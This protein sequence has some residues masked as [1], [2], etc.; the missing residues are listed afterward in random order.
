MFRAITD[1]TLGLI[2]GELFTVVASADALSGSD[3]RRNAAAACVAA[4]EV[5]DIVAGDRVRRHSAIVVGRRFVI[6][7]RYESQSVG[8]GL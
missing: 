7:V 1:G 2:G 8:R 6:D 4:P 3:K 5:L